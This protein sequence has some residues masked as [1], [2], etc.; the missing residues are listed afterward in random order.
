MPKT[1][2][3]D[4]KPGYDT[5]LAL[6]PRGLHIKAREIVL[7]ELSSS[8]FH[9]HVEFLGEE[10]QDEASF[11]KQVS[12]TVEENG[13]RKAAHAKSSCCLPVGSVEENKKHTSLGY[14]RKRYPIWS[15]PGTLIGQVWLKIA[16]DAPADRVANI[17]VLGPLLGLVQ[18]WENVNLSPTM[19]LSEVVE[20]IRELVGSSEKHF[21]F[22]SALRLWQKHA[23]IVW[24]L[25]NKEL[26]A[27][28][29]KRKYRISC[30]R[31]DS[32]KFQYT[33]QQ[34]I[35]EIAEIIVP[36]SVKKDSWKVD[37][38]SYDLE[39]VAL[40]HPHALA[41][42]LALRPYQRLGTRSFSAGNIPPDTSPPYLSGQ[43]T[44]NLV[45][46]R[47]ATAQILLHFAELS[48][49]DIVVDP[50]AGI[51]TIPIEASF[52]ENGAVGLGGDVVLTSTPPGLGVLASD[53]MAKSRAYVTSRS[54]PR[55]AINDLVAWDATNLPW[56]DASV[57]ACVSDLPF[58]Q[59]CMSSARL[60]NVLP[61][62]MLEMARILRPNTGRMVLL[63][64]HWLQVVSAMQ[65]LNDASNQFES[66][67]PTTTRSNFANNQYTVIE[68]PCDS[69]FPVNIGGLIA[70]VVIAKRGSGKAK[71]FKNHKER[72][73]KLTLKRQRQES[74]HVNGKPDKR[75][76][77]QS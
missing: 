26:L 76:A 47:P 5:Y 37:L 43:D 29:E 18:V 57:D 70:W 38:T 66:E 46:L 54:P 48:R 75:G 71:P 36:K 32:E 59:L 56:R 62:M 6:V 15:Q 33:R 69:I 12:S 55:V 51:G 67:T 52:G 1:N 68:L 73:R 64:G 35:T 2:E 58:G 24:N 77:I 10:I 23:A 34:L 41:V 17:R 39:V 20:S 60:H 61:L 22:Q 44:S 72:V 63:C 74:L 16:T 53:Y 49:G 65:S 4:N 31:T 3:A 8:S 45:N 21:P 11:V 13:N 25:S 9:V 19:S 28:E 30:L 42:G 7:E 27:L 40:I 14:F 50:A